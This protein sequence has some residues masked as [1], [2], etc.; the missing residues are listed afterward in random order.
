MQLVEQV[1]DLLDEVPEAKDTE[2]MMELKNVKGDIILENVRF[3]YD[4]NQVIICD[5]SLQIEAGKLIAISWIHRR[6]K[7]HYHQSP[8]ALLR[9][10]SR[11]YFC[12]WKRSPRN[13]PGQPEK[14]I[15][16]GFAGYL[17]FSW[18]YL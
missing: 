17:D 16:H 4:A 10:A 11:K 14:S 6:R 2:E 18:K 3:S 15:C 1:V 13:N 5:L 9:R 8:H 7:N 12:G